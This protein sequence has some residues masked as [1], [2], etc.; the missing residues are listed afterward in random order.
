MRLKKRHRKRHGCETSRVL[1]TCFPKHFIHRRT[2]DGSR[3]GV[4]TCN[5]RM[6][7]FSIPWRAITMYN[8]SPSRNS[9][10]PLRKWNAARIPPFKCSINLSTMD[11][12][13]RPTYTV[14]S[15]S[16]K[17]TYTTLCSLSKG[18]NNALDTPMIRRIHV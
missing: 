14:P 8:S 15:I 9:G 11:H 12:P 6:R 7:K 18:A 16:E 1:Y 17:T 2:T 5:G 13:V 4:E 10:S 3:S